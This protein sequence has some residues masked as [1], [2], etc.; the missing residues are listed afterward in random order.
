VAIVGFVWW[1]IEPQRS[2]EIMLAVL[3]VS[4]PCALSLAAPAAFAAAGSHLVRRGVLLT[5]GHALETLARVT[6]FV[7]DKTGT[8]TQGKPVLLH[9]IPFGAVS[10][11]DCLL[12]AASLEQASEHPLAQSFLQATGRR[13]LAVVSDSRNVPGKG[14]AGMINGQRYTIGNVALRP[15]LAGQCNLDGQELPANATVV[16]L[17]DR[18]TVLA[19]FVLADA[20][21]PQANEMVSLLQSR[22]IRVSILSGDDA[23]AVAHHAGEIGVDEWQAGLSPEQ[24]LTEV[25]R[26]QQ[27][28]AVVAMVGDGI[29]D[30][31]VLAA[32]QVSLA[33]GSGTQMARTTGDIVLLTENLLE[34]DH[35]V[36]TSRFGMSVIRQNFA[37]ALG[38]NLLV[39]PFAA[40]G[41]ISP[42]LAALGMSVSSLVVVLNAL[43]LR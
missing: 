17:C 1:R 3:V 41:F 38:Y 20:L 12:L 24:K 33:M 43:R 18:Q 40:T 22:G 30:A 5:R 27:S 29:N 16:W 4:C 32:A 35:A 37:W 13:V 2:F 11:D 15:E 31:P 42:W 34:I 23:K 26:M 25:R 36:T 14:V 10:A 19:A 6:H 28:G 7:F 21:R 8:L 9:T 39:L